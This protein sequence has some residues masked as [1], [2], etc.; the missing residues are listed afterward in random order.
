MLLPWDAATTVSFSALFSLK[1]KKKRCLDRIDRFIQLF[2]MLSVF[3]AEFLLQ[4]VYLGPTFL[5]DGWLVFD[6]FV[7]ITVSWAFTNSPITVLRSLRVFRIF[8]LVQNNEK[9]KTLLN[10][11][12]RA[13]P[14]SRGCCWDPLSLRVCLLHAFHRPLR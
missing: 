3:T 2:A 9:M 5:R 7:I 14:K 11:M 6:D 1:K 12:F 13:I 8:A 10:A 4:A